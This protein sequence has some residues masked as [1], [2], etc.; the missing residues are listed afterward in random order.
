MCICLLKDKN[1][2][3]NLI[4][5][6]SFLEQL[7]HDIGVLVPKVIHFVVLMTHLGIALALGM[8]GLSWILV[9]ILG[10]LVNKN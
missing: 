3:K 4:S 9:S 6:A 7:G 8:E 1:K 5:F 10:W 2:K